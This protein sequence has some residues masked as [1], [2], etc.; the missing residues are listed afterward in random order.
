MGNLSE[1]EADRLQME[2]YISNVPDTQSVAHFKPSA[3]IIKLPLK[4]DIEKLRSAV[5]DLAGNEAFIDL[6]SGFQATTLTQRPGVSVVT[7]NDLSGR[8]YTRIDDTL[9]E[10]PR[11]EI[12]DESE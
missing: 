11:D 2:K 5:D 7:D 8:F 9:K 4:F 12:V 3:D 6:G 10:Y 1:Y